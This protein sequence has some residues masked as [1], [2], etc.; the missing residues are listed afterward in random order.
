MDASP[1]NTDARHLLHACHNAAL[2]SAGHIW[3]SGHG[4]VLVDIHGRDF[5][6]GISGLWNV[7]VGHGRRELAEVAMRQM[8]ELAF[9][10]NYAGSSNLPAINLASELAQVC[11]PSVNRFYFTTSGAEANEAAFKTARYFWKRN[12]QPGKTHVIARHGDYHGTTCAALSATGMEKYLAAFEPR[13]PGFSWIASP[14]HCSPKRISSGEEAASELEREIIRLG[15]NNVAA[16]VAEPIVGVGGVY[17]PPPDYWPRVREI[18]D[19]HNVLLIADEVLTGFGRTGEWFALSKSDIEPDIVTFAK[20]ITSG[21]LPLGG[22]GV[23]NAIG[24]AINT[25]Q[26]ETVWLHAATYS[27]HPVACAVALENLK[28]LQQEELLARATDSGTARRE[29]LESLL[30]HPLVKEI[31]SIGLL[32]AI[33]LDN[34][35]CSNVGFELLAAAES[36]G[37]FTRA[38]AELFHLAPCLSIEADQLQRMI[39]IVRESLVAISN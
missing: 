2:Q 37:L 13:M 12:G 32:A 23:N 18:C 24:E 35:Q 20:G 26:G 29:G 22:M 14:P 30:P 31:R 3:R 34:S 33:Q 28:I 15:A 25:G 11:Y 19:A 9:V 7:Q 21:Y 39:E 38:R 27:G 1:E 5:L 17:V 16:F 10:S 4:A 8:T 36:Q 6:D